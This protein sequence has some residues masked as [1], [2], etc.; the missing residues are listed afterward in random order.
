MMSEATF[1]HDNNYSYTYI[2]HNVRHL[3]MHVYGNLGEGGWEQEQKGA[4]TTW[5]LWYELCYTLLLSYT[6]THT[7]TFPIKF[8]LNACN[9]PV[10]HKLYWVDGL[11]HT[12]QHE[13]CNWS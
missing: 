11:G 2:L 5:N 9:V 12:C 7:Y 6:H 4:A 13:V 1:C 3:I 10:E 8:I